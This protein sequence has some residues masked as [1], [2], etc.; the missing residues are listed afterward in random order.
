M[1]YAVIMHVN[2]CEQGQTIEEMCRKAAGWGFDGIEFRSRRESVE[3]TVEEYLDKLEAG[4]KA[5][6]LRQVVFGSPGPALIK[7]DARERQREVE[8]AIA[9]YREAAERF[10]VRTVNLV[11]GWLGIGETVTDDHWAWQVEGCRALADGLQGVD[12]RFGFET[13][14]GY[15]HDTIEST[16]RLVE[17]I[18]RPAIGANLDYGNMVGREDRPSLED[19]V[20]AFGGKLHYVHLKNSAPMRGV[21]GR[22]A[23]S[24]GEGEINNRQFV[25]LLIETGYDGPVCIEAPRAGDREWFAQQDLAYIKSVLADLGA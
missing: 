13:H 16:Q 3:E 17:D 23:T 5:S 15:V 7:Q 9:F 11:T 19:A 6:G 25:R 2:Y 21:K 1:G 22:F 8:N 4:V 10:G 18:D 12:I 20:K 14:R 24:L